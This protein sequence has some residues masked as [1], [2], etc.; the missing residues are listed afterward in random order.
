MKDLEGYYVP[1][2]FDRFRQKVILT[3]AGE[4]LFAA[5]EK[6]FRM[7][8]SEPKRDDDLKGLQAGDLRIGA[9]VTL[10]S[11]SAGILRI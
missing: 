9:S 8:T 1:R 4:L 11:I 5:A 6:I 10:A 7:G 2:L 3:Q